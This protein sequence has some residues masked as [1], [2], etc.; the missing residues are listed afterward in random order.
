MVVRRLVQMIR[1]K[2]PNGFYEYITEN[3][4]FR[5][6]AFCSKGMPTWNLQTVVTPIFRASNAFRAEP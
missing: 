6:K 1:N 5:L 2:S 3:G 4:S